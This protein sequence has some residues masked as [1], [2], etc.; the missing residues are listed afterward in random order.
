M[1]HY[2]YKTT[3]NETGEYYI[4]KHSTDNLDDGYQGSGTI[5]KKMINSG[6]NLTTEIIEF[7]SSEKEAYNRESEIV[8][9]DTIKDPKCLNLIVGGKGGTHGYKHTSETIEKL[10]YTKTQ[11]HKDKIGK[12]NTGKVRSEQVKQ[13]ISKT[14][15]GKTLSSEHINIISKTHKGKTV[16]DDVKRKSAKTQS[17]GLWVTPNGTFFNV[18][19]AAEANGC[20]R[21]TLRRRCYQTGKKPVPG[22]SFIKNKE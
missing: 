1:Y 9:E 5:I 19:E 7:C 18:K 6:V 4:G 15:S 13:T 22:Y 17:I 12:A 10:K 21:S 3:R 16:S 11:E 14:H 8:T 20:D 2:I